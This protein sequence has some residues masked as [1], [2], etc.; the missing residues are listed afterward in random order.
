[1]SGDGAN[2][3]FSSFYP[4]LYSHT[5]RVAFI[6]LLYKFCGVEVL[7]W[8]PAVVGIGVPLPLDQELGLIPIASRV[9]YSFYF[10]FWLSFYQI[11]RGFWEVRSMYGC[12]F[13]WH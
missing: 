10:P 13:V 8:F 6:V 5:S 12:F 3:Y 7:F 1:M 4:F 2:G 11:R 9:H